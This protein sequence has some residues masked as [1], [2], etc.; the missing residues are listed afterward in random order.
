MRVRELAQGHARD[1]P[2]LAVPGAGSHEVPA[3]ATA[4]GAWPREAI[5]R[6]AASGPRTG[7]R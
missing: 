7:V 3:T 5:P 6:A 1:E 4:A 2:L